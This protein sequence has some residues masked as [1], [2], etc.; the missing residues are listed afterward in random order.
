MAWKDYTYLNP[1]D[2]EQEDN[3]LQKE[4]L[5]S[6]KERRE[7]VERLLSSPFDDHISKHLSKLLAW[8]I[9]E[10][11][12]SAMLIAKKYNLD[13]MDSYAILDRDDDFEKLFTKNYYDGSF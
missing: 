7:F 3:I 11:D 9:I 5:K 12:D 4:M 2:E 6:M 13:I 1:P 10:E 8:G